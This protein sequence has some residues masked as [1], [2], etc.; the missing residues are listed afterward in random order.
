DSARLRA[1]PPDAGVPAWRLRRLLGSA[2][3]RPDTILEVEDERGLRSVFLRPAEQ[4]DGRELA[5]AL[6]PRGGPV[7]MWV[8]SSSRTAQVVRKLRLSAG[9]KKDTAA[10]ANPTLALV[11]DGKERRTLTLGD[12]ARVGKVRVSGDAGSDKREAWSLRDLARQLVDARARVVAL[13]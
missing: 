4:I 2:Y 9:A 7:V 10:A 13:A 8:G 11:I 1:T 6:D 3:A 12:L 5:L